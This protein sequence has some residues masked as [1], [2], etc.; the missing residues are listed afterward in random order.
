MRL[1]AHHAERLRPV[2]EGTPVAVTGGAGFIGSHLVDALHARGAHITVIDDLSTSDLDHLGPLIEL[3]PARLR[4]VHGSILEDAALA[5]A[6]AG[7]TR[8]FHL[9]ALNSV[10]RS[11]DDPERTWAVNATGTLR[12]VRAAQSVGA[13]RLVFA[14]SSSAYGNTETLPKHEDMAPRPRSPY[15]AAKLAGEHLIASA[16][17]TSDLDTAALRFFN[18][19]GPRQR[20]D[21]PYAGV[22]PRFA[23]RL[24]EGKS[25]VI[26]GDGEQT[27]DFTYVEN[28]VLAL[29]LAAANDAPLN[30]EAF[31]VGCG[32]RHSIRA[33]AELLTQELA[34]DAGPPTFTDARAGDV[35]D[36]LADLTR[37]RERLGYEPFVDFEE[38]VRRAAAWYREPIAAT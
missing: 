24:L 30:G 17:H 13:N 14:A 1:P 23:T 27:R 11:L 25:P 34:P 7:V 31:N 33:L 3:D 37:A 10:P 29:M 18:V 8:V 5:R 16:A 28:A 38:G 6:L 9:A 20:E 32:E 26:Q 2:Y 21:S 36:S 22:V 12:V 4:F 15:A 35:R 19:F